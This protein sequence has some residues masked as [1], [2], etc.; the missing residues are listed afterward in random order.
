MSGI[1]LTVIAF[2]AVAVAI[3]I[4]EQASRRRLDKLEEQME[5]RETFKRGKQDG[6]V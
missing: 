5:L 2:I 4:G 3:V 6:M 1:T